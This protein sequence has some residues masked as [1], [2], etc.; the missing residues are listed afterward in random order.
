M[1]KKM[2]ELNRAKRAAAVIEARPFTRELQLGES[3]MLVGDNEEPISTGELLDSL[4]VEAVD[5]RQEHLEGAP[6]T[7]L[8]A[9]LSDTHWRRQAVT[10]AMRREQRMLDQLVVELLDRGVRP[11]HVADVLDVS[12]AAITKRYGSQRS[13]GRGVR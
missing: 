12:R 2:R 8:W 4:A 10:D 9:A 11:A 3:V 5:L 13:T 1:G 7:E 6:L